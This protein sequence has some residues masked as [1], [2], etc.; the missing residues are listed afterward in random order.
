MHYSYDWIAEHIS[1]LRAVG[2]LDTSRVRWLGNP[3]AVRMVACAPEQFAYEY[4]SSTGL[5]TGMFT[6]AFV[7]ALTEAGDLPVT[8]SAI[9]DRIHRRVTTLVPDQR[10]EAEGPAR[11]LL[12]DTREDETHGALRVVPGSTADRITLGVAP[13]LGVQVGDEFTL[14]PPTAGAIDPAGMIGV[15]TVDRVG[16]MSASAAVTF[17]P[18]ARTVPIGTRAFRTRASALALPVRLPAPDPGSSPAMTRV[19]AGLAA[20]VAASVLVRAATDA[21]DVTVAEV[22]VDGDRLV[23]ADGFGP[24]HAPVPPAPPRSRC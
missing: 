23:V 6:E 11:R 24:L 19:V 16:A 12:F 5:R 9:M 4:T 21:D 13:L 3:K 15:A 22:R 18:G 17:R 1:R 10:P 20:E 7:R 14:M 2:A 8:W